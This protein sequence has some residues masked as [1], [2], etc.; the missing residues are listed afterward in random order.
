MSL[1]YKIMLIIFFLAAL[2][3]SSKRTFT[4]NV[5]NSIALGV[6]AIVFAILLRGKK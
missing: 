3:D 2:F 6:W 4:E 5:L 1:F